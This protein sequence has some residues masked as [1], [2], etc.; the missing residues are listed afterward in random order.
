MAGEFVRSENR[1]AQFAG[2]FLEPRGQIHSGTDAG[3]IQT[4]SA[5]YVAVQYLPN[6]Q[7]QSKTHRVSL[8]LIQSRI[9]RRASYAAINARAQASSGLSSI[10]KIANRPS[11]MNLRTSPPR[12][13]IAGTWQSKY[14]LSNSTRVCGGTRSANKVNP[15]ISDS[16]IAA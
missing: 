2:K 1:A 6:V 7:R 12:S 14:P 4:V 9:R 3:K 15:R 5:A 10:G 11:P 16:Q 13:R 8:V